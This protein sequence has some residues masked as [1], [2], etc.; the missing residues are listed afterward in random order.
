MLM[1]L[2]TGIPAFSNLFFM[3]SNL[4]HVTTTIEMQLQFKANALHKSVCTCVIKTG[5]YSLKPSP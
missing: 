3:R 2:L 1:R 5:F 4:C